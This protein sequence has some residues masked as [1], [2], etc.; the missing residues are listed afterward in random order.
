MCGGGNKKLEKQGESFFCVFV[1]FALFID[2]WT[3]K[4]QPLSRLPVWR[5]S[6][7]S[8]GSGGG[9]G[10]SGGSDGSGGS[11]GSGGSKSHS[12]E[13]KGSGGSVY[14]VLS[15]SNNSSNN[16]SSSSSSNSSSNSNN[17]RHSSGGGWIDKYGL[18]LPPYSPLAVAVKGHQP[19]VCKGE[20]LFSPC[21]AR[22]VVVAVVLLLPLCLYCRSVFIAV[23]SLLP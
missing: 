17:H 12:N 3:D 23:V 20:S 5:K 9:S 16:S 22:C 14:A 19:M 2:L 8:G 10:G 4:V 18:K 1:C 15:S 21:K 13:H 11:F 7:G 6:F